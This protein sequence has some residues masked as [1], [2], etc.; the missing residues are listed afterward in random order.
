MKRRIGMMLTLALLLLSGCGGSPS[1]PQTAS[2]STEPQSSQ[3]ASAGADSLSLY[4]AAVNLPIGRE[5]KLKAILAP[6]GAAASWTSSNEAVA[7]VDEDGKVAA[8]AVGECIVTVESGEKSAECAVVVEEDCRTV[9]FSTKPIKS[10]GEEPP[11]PTKEGG[12]GDTPIELPPDVTDVEQ[13]PDSDEFIWTLEFDD[14]FS[15]LVTNDEIPLIADVTISFVVKK[16][17]GKTGL[18]SYAGTVCCDADLDKEHFMKVINER[19]ANLGGN[20]TD[21]SENDEGLQKAP[22]TVDVTMIDD[23]AYH[24]VL[25][26]YIPEQE[27][28]VTQKL[29]I[30]ISGLLPGSMMALGEVSGMITISGTMTVEAEGQS[31][32]LPFGST[33]TSAQPYTICIYPSGSALLTFPLMARDGFA[34]N[35]VEGMLTKCPLI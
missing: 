27:R 2:E 21:Y 23:A 26:G 14:T 35:W 25:F 11:E 19:M 17:G 18:G 9:I 33:E 15:T 10:D 1:Q 7:T 16:Q 3:T 6:A 32:T 28:S 24:E 5:L 22:I 30:P 29:P 4:P 12:E 8:K 20:V 31:V 34:R 13:I